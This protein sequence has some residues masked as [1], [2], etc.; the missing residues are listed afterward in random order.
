MA[1]SSKS[2]R[3]VAMGVEFERTVFCVA[4]HL[5]RLVCPALSS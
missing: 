4:T 5:D 2:K 1:E 3:V